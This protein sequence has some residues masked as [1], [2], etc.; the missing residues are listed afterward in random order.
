MKSCLIPSMLLTS[1]SIIIV[2]IVSICLCC[3]CLCVICLMMNFVDVL[4]VSLCCFVLLL[5]SIH[6]NYLVTS[7]SP[8]NHC[9]LNSY[10]YDYFITSSNW[11]YHI[12]AHI[13]YAHT[14]DTLNTI[15]HNIHIILI[16]L[17]LLS[18][19][20]FS[21]LIRLWTLPLLA[22]VSYV[23]DNQRYYHHEFFRHQKDVFIGIK[24]LIYP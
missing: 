3:C 13:L 7:F 14:Y 22:L 19:S 4:L 24:L 18:S 23:D 1:I 12:Y 10:L 9:T 5:F 17:L 8:L 11:P 15:S 16:L 2:A 21:L 6:H 20:V